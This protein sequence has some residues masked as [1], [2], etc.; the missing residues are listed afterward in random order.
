MT[1]QLSSAYIENERK[2]YALYVLANRALP[3]ISDGLKVA[4]RRVIWTGKDGKKYK[5]ASLA[6]A[7][8]P[9][10]PHSAPD[11][12]I[13]SIT[14]EFLNN[15]PLFKGS[16]AFGSRLAPNTSA[17]PRY[18]SIQLSK[19]T[20]DVILKD[21]DLVEMIDNYDQTLKEPKNFL[22]LVPVVLLNPTDGI[23]V[24]F[25]CSILPRNLK[26]IITSQLQVLTNKP[27]TLVYPEFTPFE[28]K[29]SELLSDEKWVFR[30]TFERLS[31]FEIKVTK[32]Q[33]GT[34]YDKFINTLNKLEESGYIKDYIDS[35]SDNINIVI[36]F[37]RGY[38]NSVEDNII[39]KKLGLVTHVGENLT[40]LDFSGNKVIT[41]TYDSVIESFTSYRLSFYVKRYERLLSLLDIDI[42]KYRDIILAIANNIGQ[43]SIKISDRAEL[44]EYL[45]KIGIV[46]LDYIADLPIYK[47]TI[48]E[49][50]KIELKLTEALVTHSEYVDIISDKDK[51]VKIYISE[52]KEVL[53]TYNK[54][55]YI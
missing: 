25:A 41:P 14:G 2:T 31:S 18:T 26:D 34:T 47:F 37:P 5:T 8:M 23:G 19:F 51:Q 53:S 36:K 1:T 54:G 45:E 11:G 49:K 50:E 44:K 4:A 46:N 10:H 16:G 29:S 55:L 33:Y 21:L 48:K 32:L 13:N 28:S 30:T 6:G 43:V 17:S 52:L 35:S 15:I 7:T 42:Q 20:N 27:I 12:V 38:L 39:I 24:G 40:I 9:I 22:P 3:S